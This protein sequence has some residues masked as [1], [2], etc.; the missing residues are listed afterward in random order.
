MSIVCLANALTSSLWTDSTRLDVEIQNVPYGPRT[1]ST[2][3][4]PIEQECLIDISKLV[5]I[6]NGFQNVP[7]WHVNIPG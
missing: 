3:S 2:T 4:G 1:P 5:E 7:V 6:E